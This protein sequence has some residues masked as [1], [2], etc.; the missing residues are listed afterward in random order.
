MIYSPIH[1][2]H[3]FV[4]YISVDLY[5]EDAKFSCINMFERVEMTI[6]FVAILL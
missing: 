4:Y 1:S 6:I 5:N 2:E 3:V